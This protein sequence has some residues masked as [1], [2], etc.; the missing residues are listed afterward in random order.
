MTT[1]KYSER[2]V[3]RAIQMVTEA[4]KNVPYDAPTLNT[5][6][7]VKQLALLKLA[8]KERE[9][10]SVA[11]LD[12]R[13]RLIEWHDLF[14]GSVDSCAVCIREIAKAAL[15]VNAAACVLAHN[16]PSGDPSPGESDR[17]LT[18][19]V[20]SSLRVFDIRVVDHIVVGGGDVYSFVESGESF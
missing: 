17:A 14:F 19:E 10:F 7:A 4:A 2:T 12:A 3:R 8:A 15:A 5:T 13:L 16:H 18:R 1:T 6:I 20:S 11:L 9:V